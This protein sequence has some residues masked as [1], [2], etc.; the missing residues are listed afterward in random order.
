[1][2]K[3]IHPSMSKIKTR[4]KAIKK[5]NNIIHMIAL[6]VAAQEAGYPPFHSLSS[7]LKKL[8]QNK[9][10]ANIDQFN[11]EWKGSATRNQEDYLHYWSLVL[12]ETIKTHVMLKK[13]K[14]KIVAKFISGEKC[15]YK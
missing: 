11:P 6:N 10:S 5:E 9:L 13:L 14:L 7:Y 2:T 8:K 1:M 4:A 15:P 12:S 3:I